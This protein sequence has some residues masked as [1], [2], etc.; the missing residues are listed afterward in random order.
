VIRR[1]GNGC[2]CGTDLPGTCPGYYACPYSDAE[3]DELDDDPD[4][5]AVD[6]PDDDE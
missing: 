3:P 6:F 5:D 4:A 2:V 1:R